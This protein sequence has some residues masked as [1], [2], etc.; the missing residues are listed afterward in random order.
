V[1][2]RVAQADAKISSAKAWLIQLLHEAWEECASALAAAFS[3]S[4]VMTSYS[5]LATLAIKTAQTF[6]SAGCF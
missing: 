4:F 1:Q 2:A 6:T 5:L 3:P